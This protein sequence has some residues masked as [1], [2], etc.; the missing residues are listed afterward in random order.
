[1][2]LLRR[3][4]RPLV[5][6]YV[7]QVLMLFR[8]GYLPAPFVI[9]LLP[10][11]AVAVAAGFDVLWGKTK[12]QLSRPRQAGVVLRRMAVVALTA[13]AIG[14]VAPSWF[15]GDRTA[16]TAD[17]VA[18]QLA[19]QRWITA[20]VPQ[21][22]RM[23]V[24]DT[25]WVDLVQAGFKRK[26]GVVWFYKLDN[27]N[28]LDASVAK[29]LPDGWRDCDYIVSTPELRA[30][31]ADLPNGLLPIRQAMSSSRIVA[32]FGAGPGLVEVRKITR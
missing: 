17:V 29:A 32:S 24:D 5:A 22:S 1:L 7:L 12:E 30:G 21:Q 3:R 13:A 8:G 28:N 26:F 4:L 9:G 10:F 23:I 20:H 16:M 14:L 19:A 18:P 25:L 6:A 11:S 27:S 2:A 31:L 15:D